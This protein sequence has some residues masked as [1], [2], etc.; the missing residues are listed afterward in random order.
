MIADRRNHLLELA[1]FDRVHWH[2]VAK[3]R[4]CAAEPLLRVGFAQAEADKRVKNVGGVA[5]AV[6][7]G[8]SGLITPHR[9]ASY[10]VRIGGS[11][12][13]GDGRSPEL[14]GKVPREVGVACH[15]DEGGIVRF[16]ED[17]ADGFPGDSGQFVPPCLL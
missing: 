4:V 3:S 1:T 9:P 16:L 15:S 12:Q 5:H 7:P 6:H 13:P 11:G 10:R 8:V 14:I 2:L 17:L